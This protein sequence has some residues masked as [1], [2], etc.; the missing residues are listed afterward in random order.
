MVQ[1]TCGQLCH[2]ICTFWNLY[3]FIKSILHFGVLNNVS[4]LTV[5]STKGDIK[6]FKSFGNRTQMHKFILIYKHNSIKT[7]FNIIVHLRC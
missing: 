4:S 5:G 6:N 1:L 3:N 2:K 7:R